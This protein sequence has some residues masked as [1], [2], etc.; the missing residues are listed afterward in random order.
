MTTAEAITVRVAI[1]DDLPAVVRLLADD[2]LGAGREEDV[3][4]LP[5]AYRNAFAAMRAQ[6]GNDLLVAIQA[7]VVVGCLQLTI[8]P[9]M[10]RLGASRAQIEGVRVA[11]THRGLGI[12]ELLVRE[13]IDRALGAGCGL[14]Q[15]T[16]DTSRAD[17]QRFYERLGFEATHIGM[18]LR[19]ERS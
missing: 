16:T 18:K 3:D 11:A 1:E 8:I 15:L 5:Q 19:L 14:V 4:P 7:G 9:G 2:P 10:S 12:G 6:G 13:A 17:A